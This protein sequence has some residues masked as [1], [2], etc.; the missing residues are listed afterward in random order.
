MR[1]RRRWGVVFYL[2]LHILISIFNFCLGGGEIIIIYGWLCGFDLLGYCVAPAAD[3]LSENERCSVA[4]NFKKLKNHS[5]PKKSIEKDNYYGTW[6]DSLKYAIDRNV[7]IVERIY[8]LFISVSD[9]MD[10]CVVLVRTRRPSNTKI[11]S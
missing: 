2:I 5:K 11:V 7:V 4:Q 8:F 6:F 3:S 9:D 10:L 1:R